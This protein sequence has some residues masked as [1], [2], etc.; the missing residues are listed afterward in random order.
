MAAANPSS[1]GR[2]L[3]EATKT[4]HKMALNH[5]MRSARSLAVMKRAMGGRAKAGRIFAQDGRD[6]IQPNVDLSRENHCVMRAARRKP[7]GMDAKE[8][9]VE[10]K[11]SMRPM[12]RFRLDLLTG[13]SRA[14]PEGSGSSQIYNTLDQLALL[15]PGTKAMSFGCCF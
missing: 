3:S 4:A 13:C 8:Y 6:T 14:S 1:L 9:G 5:A 2:K 12:R 7:P 11:P 10:S 15:S